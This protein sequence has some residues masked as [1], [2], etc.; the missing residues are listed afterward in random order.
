MT[1][2]TPLSNTSISHRATTIVTLTDKD[3]GD[4]IARQ[5]QGQRDAHMML[6]FSHV[7]RFG[8]AGL[9]AVLALGRRMRTGRGRLSLVNL[10][11]HVHGVFAAVGLDTLFA[12]HRQE[13]DPTPPH[14]SITRT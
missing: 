7:R 13:P 2:A 5:L 10:G 1:N 12:P 6:D 8:A 4:Q 3:V 14:Q 9:T 11:V